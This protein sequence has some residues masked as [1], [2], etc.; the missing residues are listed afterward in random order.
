MREIFP[1][2]MDPEI[3]YDNIC[4]KVTRVE[5]HRS[6]CVGTISDDTDSRSARRDK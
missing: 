6:G 2:P 4:R 3:S 1:G 5:P